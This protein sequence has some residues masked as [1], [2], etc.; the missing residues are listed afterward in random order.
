MNSIDFLYGGDDDV[1]SHLFRLTN[2]MSPKPKSV[3]LD[4]FPDTIYV[5]HIIITERTNFLGPVTNL[6]NVLC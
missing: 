2:E 5:N 6:M 4:I 1:L 3:I